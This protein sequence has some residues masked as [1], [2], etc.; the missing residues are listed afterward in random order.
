MKRR[1]FLGLSVGGSLATL[2]AIPTGLAAGEACSAT[3][4]DIG[5]Q[6]QLFMDDY[7]V[8]SMQPGVYTLLNQPQKHGD[9]PLIRLG[10]PWEEQG[11]LSHA[12]DCGKVFYDEEQAKFRFHGVM[13]N[14]EWSK[15]FLFYAE[16]SDGLNWVKPKLG[17][18]KYLGYDT[19]FID[20]PFT[21]GFTE[22]V[23][24]DLA[25][26][27]EQERYKM[28][29]HEKRGSQWGMYPA[30][31]PDGLHWTAYNVD[32][33]AV[34]YSSDTNNNLLWD[35]GRRRYMLYLRT[36]TRLDHWFRPEPS[37]PEGARART[38]AWASS[39]DFLHWD[40]PQDISNPQDRFV[41][42]HPDAADPIGSRDFYT[43]EVLPY[44]GGYVG[45]TSVYHNMFEL[46][47][48]GI[49]IGKAQSSWLDRVDVQLLWS[50]DGRWFQRVGRRRVFLPNG[51]E[52][53]WD[54]DLIYTVQPPI[55]RPHLDEIWIYYEG[56]GGHHW[57]N[58]RG[59]AQ[60]G[61]VGLAILRLDGFISVTGRGALTTRRLT[62]SGNRLVLNVL[63]VDKYAGAGYGT[64]AVEVLDG[65]TSQ[66]IVGFTRQACD[67]F[68]GD[69][70]RHVVTWS[71]KPDVGALAG[72]PVKL[73]FHLD[74]AKL[75]SFQF[76]VES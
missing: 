51:P 68:G 55:V 41:C 6:K 8:E 72:R 23:L 27:E 50:R 36:Y 37:Y 42:F 43:L 24:Q 40:S 64:V 66:A 48:A 34:P 15:Q 30:H 58:Q 62:F 45:F 35:A 19:N 11:G 54:A 61:Q 3:P 20:L 26:K 5:T 65:D 57:F 38:P 32:R 44:E 59:E 39:E 29:Y 25:T 18:V 21:D 74:K 76:R 13:V 60:R 14:W 28:I 69:A 75:F 52:G 16:S 53:T 7:I 1:E 12:G 10:S 17:Q 33:P 46:T 71:G 9:N 31:S 49:D 67:V 63:G 22:T 4:V 2:S 70:V 73:R 56:F 47:P